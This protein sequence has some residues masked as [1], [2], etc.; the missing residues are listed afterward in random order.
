MLE[1]ITISGDDEASARR[2]QLHRITDI[3][4]AVR[5]KN[6]VNIYINDKFYCSL[7][8]SQVV[9]LG[10]KVGRSLSNEEMAD[11]KRASDFGKFYT[12]ALEFVLMRPHSVKEVRD[13]L[14]R[15]TLA[16][17]VR[18]K[19]RK[20]GEYQTNVREGYDASLVPL[21]LDRL[22]QRNYLNDRRFAQF[23][24]ENRNVK[25]GISIKKIQS[26]LAQKG[27]DQQIIEE[28]LQG[29]SRNERD[30]LRKIIARKSNRYKNPQKLIQYLIRQGFNYSDILEELD[31][32]SG[33]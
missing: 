18:V 14:K 26:E 13:Y 25:K 29:T 31:F 21:V 15:K 12:Q 4:E 1:T 6:R 32:S 30:E 22:N 7:D 20:T 17:K 16:K 10:I 11:L 19:N 23:W 9:D 8:I 3:K 33:I 28:V 27:V 24:V 2:P 5:N